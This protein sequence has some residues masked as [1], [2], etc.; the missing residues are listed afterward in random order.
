MGLTGLNSLGWTIHDHLKAHRPKMFLELKQNGTLN[1]YV[2]SQQNQINDSLT[3]LE[4]QGLQPHEAEEMLR[5]QIY[6]PSEEDVPNL[7][8]TIQ[9]Y[10]E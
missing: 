2:L 1:Q 9:P 7:G 4:H 5:D 6:P 3:F 10:A 8:E